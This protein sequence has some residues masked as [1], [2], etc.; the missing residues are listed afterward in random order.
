[1]KKHK[2]LYLVILLSIVAVA[3]LIAGIVLKWVFNYQLFMGLSLLVYSHIAYFL[4]IKKFKTCFGIT[5]IAGIF[6]IIQ[7]TPYTIGFQ[8]IFLKFQVIP[9]LFFIVFV[10][11]NRSQV[12]DMIQDQ[13][14]ATAD[15]KEK[16]SLAKYES[17]KKGF[18]SLSD[19][20]IENRLNKVLVPE[21]RKA[22]N[23]IQEERSL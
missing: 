13:F 11:L 2:N 20:E 14:T 21:A 7:F 12:M 16:N 3:S 10:S 6:N 9:T 4:K 1:M 5:L 18:I 23:E 22:L 15:E 8:F 19:K 17:F